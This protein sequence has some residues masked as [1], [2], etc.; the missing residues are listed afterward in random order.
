MSPRRALTRALLGGIAV[1]TLGV[2]CGERP[3]GRSEG[4]PTGAAARL[5]PASAGER[6]AREASPWEIAR[7]GYAWS[8]PRDHRA[9]PA[10]RTEWWYF[11]GLLAEAGES[12]PRFGYQFTFFRIGL[13]AEPPELDSAWST[14]Q[15]IMGHA[16]VTDLATGRHV[17]SELL[18]RAAPL[19]GGFPDA[20]DPRLAW[21]R[22]PAGT[23][24][25]WTLSWTGDAFAF[26][27]VDESRDV[28]IDLTAEPIRPVV[29][30]GDGGLSTKG[31]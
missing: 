18:Y 13:A 9:H 6:P 24:G 30:H 25:T 10:Y 11:T 28:E 2:G 12:E 4:E 19:R 26:T 5:A 23:D 14:G 15:A 21:S 16:A 20:P 22:A 3:A 27:A 7:P 31:P 29:L 17:F 1:A 8:F